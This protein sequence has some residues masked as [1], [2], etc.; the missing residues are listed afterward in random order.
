M[1]HRLSGEGLHG[2]RDHNGLPSI[3]DLLVGPEGELHL[4]HHHDPEGGL[5]GDDPIGGRDG[6]PVAS[7]AIFGEGDGEQELL[8]QGI[9]IHGLILKDRLLPAG[10]GDKSRDALLGPE[11]NVGG[12]C[13]RHLRRKVEGIPGA[14]VEGKPFLLKHP[15]R[16][17]PVGQNSYQEAVAEIHLED[18]GVVLLILLPDLIQ[19][20]YHE[21]EFVLAQSIDL[22]LHGNGEGAP[23]AQ[24]GKLLSE[25]GLVVKVEG[26]PCGVEG[27]DYG[28][29]YDIHLEDDG[30]AELG[31]PRRPA[32][33]PYHEIRI[34]DLKPSGLR[35]EGVVLLIGFGHLIFGIE[36]ELYLVLPGDRAPSEGGYGRVPGG[37]ARDLLIL[38][39]LP[40]HVEGDLE[41]A[42]HIRSSRVLHL[43][44]DGE[45]ASV[46][47]GR[48]FG[49]NVHIF[50]KEIGEDESVF[51]KLQALGVIGLIGFN[52][53]PHDII[54]DD[55]DLMLSGGGFYLEDEL[56]FLPG[57]KLRHM[58]LGVELPVEE[59][60]HPE[61]LGRRI[62]DVPDLGFNLNVLFGAYLRPFGAVGERAYHEVGEEDLP[63][64]H[65]G[66]SFVVLL[67]D[68]GDVVLNVV[69][70][71]PDHMN[72][73]LRNPREGDLDALPGIQK[74][75]YPLVARIQSVDVVSGE[76]ALLRGPEAPI[77]HL[78][79]D[80]HEISFFRLLR[81]PAEIF[82]RKI[83]PRLLDL[84]P[85]A[86]ARLGLIVIPNG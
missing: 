61:V 83:R 38:N 85:E 62:S 67:I 23:S 52:N 55:L 3:V 48:V 37:K 18:P 43:R 39:E 13:P 81:R 7:G 54:G 5:G 66:L 53:L 8:P 86:R 17:L 14:V 69:C 71:D 79:S 30:I 9:V 58:L 32:H 78:R 63:R 2:A 41:F 77:P 42:E 75:V 15:K 33:I 24:N 60:A 72:S 28:L 35:D 64:R 44:E 4:L 56:P 10:H 21:L 70:F 34:E 76:E 59:E 25:L 68:F 74:L 80:R 12:A 50:H 46:G 65:R 11:R 19:R 31:L 22:P 20:I 47:K 51:G 16:I 27:G 84:H 36:H 26:E 40:V 29:I 6:Y 73:L 45:G 57:L 1:G 82:D 49:L